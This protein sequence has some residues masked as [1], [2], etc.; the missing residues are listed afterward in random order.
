MDHDGFEVK[1][2]AVRPGSRQF[3]TASSDKSLRLWDVD[4]A[5]PTAQEC[6]TPIRSFDPANGGHTLEANQVAF[7]S[8]GKRA[9]SSSEDAT[10]VLWDVETGRAIRRL[11]HPDKEETRGVAFMPGDKQALSVGKNPDVIRWDLETGQVLDRLRG[12]RGTVYYV[13]VS[14]DGTRAI[15]GADD[16]TVIV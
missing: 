8:D 1:G 10:L 16:N 2:I 14:P 13:A 7:S 3:M 6:D 11:E 5:T 4:C 15:S 9:L 12:H